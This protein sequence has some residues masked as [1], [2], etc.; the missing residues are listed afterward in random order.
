MSKNQEA[1]SQGS[2]AAKLEP[3]NVRIWHSLGQ[4]YRSIGRLAESAS[5]FERAIEL[6]PRIGVYRAS[7]AICYGLIGRPDEA[8]DQ[9]N[10]AR[11]AAGDQGFYLDICEKIA[12][13]EQDDALKRLQN[14]I[15]KATI[16]DFC[17][18]RSQLKY[19]LLKLLSNDS[20]ICSSKRHDEF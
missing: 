5:C 4:V 18:T 12:L 7:L 17:S 13:G 9:I 14:A 11:K 10:L 2:K 6:A 20:M 8:R 1:I 19:A 3:S 16:R 15:Y